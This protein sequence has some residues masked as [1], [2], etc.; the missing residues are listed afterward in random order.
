MGMFWKGLHLKSL[1]GD[2]E[3]SIT[4]KPWIERGLYLVKYS[5][6]LIFLLSLFYC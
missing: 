2:D 5:L 1:A 6:Y 3:K 4:F